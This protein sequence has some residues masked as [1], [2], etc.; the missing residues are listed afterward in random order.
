MGQGVTPTTTGWKRSS[1]RGA[2]PKRLV[3][4]T[5]LA[6]LH[7]EGRLLVLC[8]RTRI[9]DFIRV[10]VADLVDDGVEWDLIWRLARAHGVAPLVYR[11]LVAICPA[12]VPATVHELFRRHIQANALLNSLLAKE[13]ASV[14]EA[15]AA[16]GVRTIPFKGVTLAQFA[17]GD[18]ALRECADLDLIVD[19]TSVSQAR[20]V[21]WSQGY[22][23][24]SRNG[25]YDESSDEPYHFFQKRNGIIAVD[26]QWTMAGPRFEFRL[27]RSQLWA[28]VRAVDLPTKSVPGLCPEELLL[29]LCVHGAKHGWEQLKW[30]CDVA[31]LVTRRQTLDWSR[32]LF[33][34][35]EWRCRRMVLLGLA[36]AKSLFD[37]V[38]PRAVLDAIETD[39]TIAG[40]LRHMPKQLLKFPASGI[41]EQNV[42]GL[43]FLLKDSWWER[44]KFGISLC[45]SE[46]AVIRRPLP[47]FVSQPALRQLAVWLR[48]FHWLAVKCLPSARMRRVIVRWLQRSA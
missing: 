26:L 48:P 24:T 3:P 19:Q 7:A 22:Q 23:L 5:G 27:D 4:S 11:N 25:H 47:W 9:N 38:L 12:A 14:V 20:Q 46:A 37:I 41:D 29:L 13:L 16:K 43:H 33:L 31:E 39:W 44:W 34:A 36:L 6:H 2:M 1:R 42:E 45:R 18:L 28:R 15:M 30:A 40:L 32:L 17:Y 35:K 8:A 21:L 10:E